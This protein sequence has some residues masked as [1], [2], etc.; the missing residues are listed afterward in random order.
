MK[1]QSKVFSR[2][3]DKVNV[4]GKIEDVVLDFNADGISCKAVDSAN[5]M[6]LEGLL[7]KEKFKDYDCSLLGEIGIAGLGRFAG[8]VGSLIGELE[9][10]KEDNYLVVSGGTRK[11]RFVLPNTEFIKEGREFPEIEFD[12]TFKVNKEIFKHSVADAS[13][14]DSSIFVLELKGTALSVRVGEQDQLEETCT[15]EVIQTKVENLK[16]VIGD[17]LGS[18]IKGADAE[19]IISAKAEAP[20]FIEDLKGDGMAFK[21]MVAPVIE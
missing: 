18:V 10:Q 3:L 6:M 19:L 8:I 14:V 13:I 17:V 2:F 11:G 1:I 4:G 12:A 9:L 15:V 7:S 16:V 5:T 20:M 21:Y